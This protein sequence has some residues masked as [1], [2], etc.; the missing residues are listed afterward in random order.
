MNKNFEDEYIKSAIDDT[1]DLWNR[2]EAGIDAKADST[3]VPKTSKVIPFYKKYQGLLI[4][5][6]CLILVV[7]AAI[8]TLQASHGQKAFSAE[9]TA[10]AAEAVPMENTYMAEAAMEESAVE[11]SPAEESAAEESAPE[12]NME[13]AETSAADTAETDTIESEKLHKEEAAA[14]TIQADTAMDAGTPLDGTTLR[15]IQLVITEVSTD[16]CTA[17]IEEDPNGYLHSGDTLD[18]TKSTYLKL[19]FEKGQHYTVTMNYYADE[20]IPYEVTKAVKTN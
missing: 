13:T 4:A 18:F 11:E 8:I 7:P 17:A 19:S 2:I 9:S 6:L 15:D 16:S 3:T 1:P 12:P 20:S 14:E 10:G 5:C